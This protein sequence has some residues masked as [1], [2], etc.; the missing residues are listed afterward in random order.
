MC[1]LVTTSEPP[2]VPF[3]E[4]PCA[5][6]YNLDY[7]QKLTRRGI[8]TTSNTKHN[9]SEQWTCVMILLEF[10]GSRKKKKTWLNLVLVT[11]RKKS[12]QYEFDLKS[13]V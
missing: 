5:A 7:G 11:M 13:K 10:Y 9:D 3:K 4:P 12:G 2:L 6:Q 8:H 1:R